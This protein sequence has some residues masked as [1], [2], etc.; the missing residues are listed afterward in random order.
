MTQV[1][2]TSTTGICKSVMTYLG[3]TQY[4][5]FVDCMC[6]CDDLTVSMILEFTTVGEIL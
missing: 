3:S 6:F 5:K 1:T 4:G 2:H